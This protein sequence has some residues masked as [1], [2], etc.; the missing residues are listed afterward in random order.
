MPKPRPL[1]ATSAEL[2]NAANGV[3]PLGRK[4]YVTLPTFAFG[5]PTTELA[6]LYLT[7]SVLDT[8]RRTVRGHFATRTGRAALVLK[9]V[10]WALLVLIQRRNVKSQPYFEAG[11]RDALGADYESVAAESQPAR[12]RGAGLPHRVV[13]AALR[14]EERHRPLRPASGEHRRHLA[15]Q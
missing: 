6:P 13:A 1:L 2:L 15:A 11:L 12:R 9:V 7:G 4:G 5:W 3:Q 10:T 8:V 14:G